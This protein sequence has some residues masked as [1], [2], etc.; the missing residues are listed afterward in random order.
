MISLINTTK[1]RHKL[2]SR[3]RKSGIEDTENSQEVEQ[4]ET[5]ESSQ[6]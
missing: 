5:T 2:H 4:L 6:T 1:T 3:M